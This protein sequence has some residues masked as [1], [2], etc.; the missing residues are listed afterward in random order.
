MSIINQLASSLDRRDEIPNQELAKRII[1]N[2][3]NNAIQELVNH[4]KDK[5]KNIQ[6]D[7]I[8][9]LYEVGEQKP[10]MI[11]GHAQI[12]IDLLDNK[13][14]RLVW[15]AM[16][17]IDC[18]TLDEPKTVYPV[19]K[20]LIDIADNGS[21]IT[22]DHLVSILIKLASKKEYAEDAFS[23]LDEQLM[24]CPTN[25]LPMYAENLMPIINDHNKRVFITTLSSRLPEIEKESKRKRVEKVIKKLG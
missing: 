11:A 18:I 21:V 16:T 12:F 24:I 2:N 6:N 25:Q 4:L 5:N 17:A 1:E 10:E 13:S 14:N 22:R 15:G 19:L 7:C 20:K 23:L 9:V 3:D 8:K